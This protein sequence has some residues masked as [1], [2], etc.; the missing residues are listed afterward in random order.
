MINRM[1]TQ[2]IAGRR[3]RFFIAFLLIGASICF[4]RPVYIWDSAAPSLPDWLLE[5]SG[6][7]FLNHVIAVS[8]A[9]FLCFGAIQWLS[10][11]GFALPERGV[12][13]A[14]IILGTA[15]AAFVM[16][17]ILLWSVI[18][19]WFK[20]NGYGPEHIHPFFELAD[21]PSLFVAAR[22][23]ID[24]W[25]LCFL[26]FLGLA[27]AAAVK[28][29]RAFVWLPLIWTI[30]LIVLSTFNIS[31]KGLLPAEGMLL[32]VHANGASPFLITSV[33]E[34]AVL[35]LWCLLYAVIARGN[36]T[37]VH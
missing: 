18:I 10:T 30:G 35:I 15:V 36:R 16:V 34:G 7:L 29:S 26:I 24:W 11:S 20:F 9:M 23:F 27:A 25:S 12:F 1:L 28:K 32:S 6:S 22:L 21:S 19:G 33:N 14:Y 4:F 5:V 8:A 3:K 31:F 17:S 37:A 2:Y 13:F